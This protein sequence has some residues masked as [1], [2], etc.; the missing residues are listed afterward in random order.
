MYLKLLCALVE[1]L[2]SPPT[3]MC[4]WL[5]GGLG[6]TKPPLRLPEAL[7][8]AGLSRGPLFLVAAVRG[9]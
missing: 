7:A 4:A 5:Q 8:T 3:C 1:F 2:A 9:A 6:A